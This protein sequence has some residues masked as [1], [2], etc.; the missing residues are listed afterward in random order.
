MVCSI[1][2][3]PSL[4]PSLHPA[5]PPSL[6]P[7]LPPSRPT[8]LPPSLPPSIPP[9]LPPSLAHSLPPTLSHPLPPSPPSSLPP[10]PPSVHPL[11]PLPSL[12]HSL[13]SLPPLT[14]SSP[15]LPPSLPPRHP[16]QRYFDYLSVCL[17]VSVPSPFFLHDR[18]TATKFGTRFVRY[19]TGSH[20]KKLTHPRGIP[21][22]FKGVSTIKLQCPFVCLYPHPPFLFDTTVGPRNWHTYSD[23]YGT[24]SWVSTLPLSA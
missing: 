16:L 19:G 20:L 22:G 4:P 10:H 8:S 9:S 3:S 5:I 11:P 17:C 13:P 21:E 7:S 2:I 1:P 23:R 15:S 6:P 14:S 24:G 12:P 18:R